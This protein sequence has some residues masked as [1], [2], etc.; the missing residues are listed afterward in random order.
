MLRSGGSFG[1]HGGR[2]AVPPV[3]TMG[4]FGLGRGEP[5]HVEFSLGLVS[6]TP[7]PANPPVRRL[8]FRWQ[9][10][11]KVRRCAPRRLF[12]TRRP[13][14]ALPA[15]VLIRRAPLTVPRPWLCPQRFGVSRAVH[16]R[17]E[18]AAPRGSPLTYE[19]DDTLVVPA[20]L[21][22]ARNEGAPRAGERRCSGLKAHAWFGV[23]M[24]RN[25]TG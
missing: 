3:R 20:T 19:F 22:K 8:A 23:E 1:S 9:R 4:L 14:K 10:G 16:P 17:L 11:A 13:T 7:W 5:V 24:L 2:V 21:Y 25:W 18:E 15:W 12:L 6:L